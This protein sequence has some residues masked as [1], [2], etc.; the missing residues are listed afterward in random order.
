M[1]A[2]RKGGAFYCGLAAIRGNN[3]LVASI[4][5]P[6]HGLLMVSLSENGESGFQMT[7]AGEARLSGLALHSGKICKIRLRPAPAD[8]GI[9]F[10]TPPAG[11]GKMTEIPAHASSIIDTRLCTRLGAGAQSI[12]TVEH[13]LAAAS[14]LGVDNMIIETDADELPIF[15][16]SAAPYVEA[17]KSVGLSQNWAPRRAIRIMERIEVRDGQRS[18]IAEPFD[19]RE[20][21]VSIDYPDAAIGAHHLTLDLDSPDALFRLAAARTF[22]RLSDVEA[23]RDAGLS[24]GG[25][26]ENAIVVDGANILNEEGLRDPQEFALHKALDLV[27]DLRLAAAPVIGRIIAVRPGHDLNARFVR[28]LLERC[29]V[30]TACAEG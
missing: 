30:S 25:S 20:I 1:S 17:M 13:L 7:L 21:D 16:G 6:T 12:G 23:M 26:L 22:C 8:R 18:I 27:G 9:V 3:Q 4:F 19:G 24:L 29:A 15:D 14:I 10:L 28:L 11:G 2:A 5:Q